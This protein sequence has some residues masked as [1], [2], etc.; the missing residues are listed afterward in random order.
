METFSQ[1]FVIVYHLSQYMS[2]CTRTSLTL[3]L[4][5]IN[6]CNMQVIICITGS[7]SWNIPGT[8]SDSLIPVWAWGLYYIF[9]LKKGL[10]RYYSHFEL[11]F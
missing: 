5:H 11:S 8:S 1:L 2:H 6:I 10:P 7:D 9:C 3:Y 4:H